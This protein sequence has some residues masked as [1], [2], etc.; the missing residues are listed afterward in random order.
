MLSSYLLATRPPFLSITLLACLIG[1]TFNSSDKHTAYQVAA[2]ILALLAHAA[3]NV[4]NDYY[5]S[6]NGSDVNN[7]ERIEP[8]TGGSR[9]I[10]KNFLTENQVKNFSYAIFICVIFGGL[11]LSYLTTWHL[12]WI[13]AFGL[14]LG[15]AYSAT[16]ISL[17]SRG[18]FGEIA[19]ALTWS[20][21][22]FGSGMLYAPTN[23]ESLI[24]VSLA[25]GIIASTILFNNQIPDIQADRQARKNTLASQL[26]PAS[27]PHVYL[28][29]A[30]LGL[31]TFLLSYIRG[32]YSSSFDLI[33]LIPSMTLCLVIYGASSHLQSKA[34]R[35]HP[36]DS[37]RRKSLLKQ[38]ILL[39]IIGAHV[40]GGII[41][42][43]R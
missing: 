5:D 24:W 2:L 31:L 3:A 12:L 38:S 43:A 26:N 20:L 36:I 13:G 21:I 23:L 39:T 8:F 16:P 35:L 33:L 42:F 28:G 37:Q 32:A 4:I 17:M 40:F 41:L 25:F 10:Q 7:R 29:F 14:F 30:S 18:I 15:W 34:L 6:K 11:V 22:V 1:F 9:F 19:I 27:I